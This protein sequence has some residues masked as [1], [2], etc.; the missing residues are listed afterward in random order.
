LYKFYI[1]NNPPTYE[2]QKGVYSIS[3]ASLE[4]I[5]QNQ[6]QKPLSKDEQITILEGWNI[7]DID[8]YLSEKGLIEK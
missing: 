8:I 4:D 7:Y 3:S 6:F 2:L 1:R 5:I